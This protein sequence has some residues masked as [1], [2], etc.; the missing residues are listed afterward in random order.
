MARPM[1][2]ISVVHPA[3]AAGRHGEEQRDQAGQDGHRQERDADGEAEP[4]ALVLEDQGQAEED[5]RQLGHHHDAEQGER[6]PFAEVHEGDDLRQEQPGDRQQDD[7][8][9]E[10]GDD[11]D[12]GSWTGGRR[13]RIHGGHRSKG[14]STT[15]RRHAGPPPVPPCA[16]P[17]AAI[18]A[19][20]CGARGRRSLHPASHRD[21]DPEPDRHP[22]A[23]PGSDPG[24]ERHPRA[25]AR[26]L[27]SRR[28]VRVRRAPDP[29]HRGS[30]P[31]DRC[32]GPDRG[33]RDQPRPHAASRSSPCA[34]P[35]PST[36]ICSS[37]RSPPRPSASAMGACRWSSRGPGGSSAPAP[38]G[39]R[40]ARRPWA[41]DPLDS[42]ATLTIPIVANRRMNG[43]VSFDLQLLAGEALLDPRG[44]RP[45]MA[46]GVRAVRTIQ[47]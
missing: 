4:G 18:G 43:P 8:P 5:D 2:T 25:D 30:Q 22:A 37:R 39:S 35:P 7:H 32:L 46:A 33:D 3:A 15:M 40:P 45:G 29:G 36:S 17:C 21:A 41:G 42:S 47:P 12:G 24:A 16:P 14:S 13:S 28:P 19:A 6:C 10:P 11:A 20:V 38:T 1:G 44:W 23:D 31:G 26:A 27:L 34:G 9:G